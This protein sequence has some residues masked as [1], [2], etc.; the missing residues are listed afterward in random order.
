M[1]VL[2]LVDDDPGV[3]LLV[4][5]LSQQ[6]GH[7]VDLYPDAETA[8]VGLS[9][10]MPDLALLDLNLP[11]ASGLDLARRIRAEQRY[12]QLPLTHF[13]QLEHGDM[14]LAAFAAGMDF[15]LSKDLL[16][17]PEKWSQRL[18]EIADNRASR[19]REFSL[20]W[21]GRIEG[22]RVPPD[23]LFPLQHALRHPPIRALGLDFLETFARLAIESAAGSEKAS[24]LPLSTR[25]PDRDVSL[26]TLLAFT[27]ALTRLLGRAAVVPLREV[28]DSILTRLQQEESP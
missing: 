2:I 28:V 19:G 10:A 13:G 20:T 26:A 27:D 11:G 12:D 25:P 24:W 8:W 23:A 15:F 17:Q 22:R 1:P 7:S 4:R 14:V 6:C 3:R 16:C 9:R 18:H 21:Q 5:R